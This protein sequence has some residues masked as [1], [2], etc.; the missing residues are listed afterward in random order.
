MVRSIL[1]L[2]VRPLLLQLLLHLPVRDVLLHHPL[3][4]HPPQP[5]RPYPVPH[6]GRGPEELVG[7]GR[8]V[9]QRVQTDQRKDSFLH[10][11]PLGSVQWDYSPSQNISRHCSGV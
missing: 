9:L 3:Q 8:E 6:E 7:E 1:P 4:V 11:K 5:R 10:S 2:L